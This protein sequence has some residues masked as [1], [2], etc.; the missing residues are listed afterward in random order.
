MLSNA[1]YLASTGG[2]VKVRVRVSALA[3]LA[4]LRFL[5]PNTV[6]VNRFKRPVS[7]AC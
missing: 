6:L 7:A 2:T 1:L 5:D 3:S 4:M